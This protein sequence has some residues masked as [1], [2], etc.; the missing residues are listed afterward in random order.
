MAKLS[1][2]LLNSLIA[3]C[4]TWNCGVILR[5]AGEEIGYTVDDLVTLKSAWHTLTVVP[6]V[7]KGWQQW[8]EKLNHS[9]RPFDTT[10]KVSDGQAQFLTGLFNIG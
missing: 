8:V 1:K 7:R 6:C 4:D 9:N 10:G 3:F 2:I 5:I